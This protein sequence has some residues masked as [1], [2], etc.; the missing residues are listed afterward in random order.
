LGERELLSEESAAYAEC[1]AGRARGLSG[2]GKTA[3][4]EEL[5]CPAPG[6]VVASNHAPLVDL[7]WARKAVNDAL[8]GR[9]ASLV[10]RGDEFLVQVDPPL[11]PDVVPWSPLSRPLVEARVLS[12]T[13]KMGAPSFSL[14]AGAGAIGGACPG[15]G[16]GQPTTPDAVQRSQGKVVLQVLNDDRPPDGDPVEK[17]DMAAAVCAHCYAT[18]GNYLYTD[19][20]ARGILRWAWTEQALRAPSKQGNSSEFV[21]VLIEA[22]DH[23][24][25]AHGEAEP[26]H[27][28]CEGVRFF[29]I[30]DSGDFYSEAYY[31]AWV[32]IAQAF[33]PEAERQTTIFWSPT[34]MWAMGKKWIDMVAETAGGN[35]IVRPSGYELNQHAPQLPG[36]WAAATTVFAPAV[37]AAAEDGLIQ[38][39]YDWD[40]QAYAV[41]NGPSCR[42]A[43]SPLEDEAGNPLVGC[44]ACWMRPDLR[45]NYRAH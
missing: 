4:A 16:A 12:W 42:G 31:R 19:N 20:V 40:C 37:A 28:A 21:D 34:R 30:H 8:V 45:V 22:V 43:L 17:I 14:P 5:G 39:P 15:A 2:L 1:A 13:S 24:D 38:V 26:L 3:S 33:T 29:R 35:F 11:E 25:Y 23:A 6:A 32:E 36:G 18:T 44:R 10:R 41:D 27:W 9:N 7:A